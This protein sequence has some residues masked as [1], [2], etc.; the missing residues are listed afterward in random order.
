MLQ[1][2]QAMLEALH[3]VLSDLLVADDDQ[4]W[5]DDAVEADDGH[6]VAVRPKVVDGL[7]LHEEDHGGRRHDATQEDVPGHLD[8]LLSARPVGSDDHGAGT[9]THDSVFR[10]GLASNCAGTVT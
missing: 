3:D 9:R 5:H 6:A 2:A 7:E 1:Q 8:G 10:P 4:G